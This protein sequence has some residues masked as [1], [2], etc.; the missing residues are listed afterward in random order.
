MINFL[1]K[2][3]WIKELEPLNFEI[4]NQPLEEIINQVISQ[5]KNDRKGNNFYFLLWGLLKTSYQTYKAICEISGLFAKDTK[6]PAQAYILGRSLIDALFTIVTLV[7]KPFEHTRKYLLA[8]YRDIWEEYNRELERYVNDPK[9][10]PY[11]DNK[12]KLLDIFLKSYKLS[13]TQD[14]KVDPRVHIKY[15]LIPSQLLKSNMVCSETRRFLKEIYLWR[16]KQISEWSHQAWGGMAIVL[17]TTMPGYHWQPGKFKSDAV[18]TGILF[19]LMILSEIEASC[20][21]GFEQKL[22]YIWTILK[23]YHFEEATYYYHLRYDTLLQ[24]KK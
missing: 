5:L 18:F 6:Y 21:Y 13:L 8:G 7:E 3:S 11:L 1:H 9:W 20:N 12:K 19:T 15:W 4:I 2:P 17:F 23:K 14:E 16:Y 10:K 24:K 22:R